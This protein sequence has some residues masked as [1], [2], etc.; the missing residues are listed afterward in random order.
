MLFVE[1]VDPSDLVGLEV[2]ECRRDLVGVGCLQVLDAGAEDVLGGGRLADTARTRERGREIRR[3]KL[4]DR[5]TRWGW[6]EGIVDSLL[7]HRQNGA[8][9][10]YR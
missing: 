10:I 7:K 4:C 6:R 9:F 8:L 5:C 1:V 2:V 3:L